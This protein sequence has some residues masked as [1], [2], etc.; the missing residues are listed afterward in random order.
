MKPEIPLERQ[1]E[2]RIKTLERQV[3]ALNSA[4]P[5][6]SATIDDPGTLKVRKNGQDLLHVGKLPGTNGGL[7]GLVVYRED[8]TL[9]FIVGAY[10]A[11]EQYAAL[12]DRSANVIVSDDALSG[13]GLARPYIPIPF[14]DGDA[15]HWGGTSSGTFLALYTGFAYRQHPKF[16]G[17]VQVLA[18]AGT[19]GELEL[20]DATNSVQLDVQS[21]AAAESSYKTFSGVDITSTSA[22]YGLMSLQWRV[23]VTGGAGSIHVNPVF[24]TGI[25]S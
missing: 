17:I 12:Q 18:D 14:G 4:R 9:A 10:A 6:R 22:L 23:R 19:S 2:E 15:S 1:F 20:W 24:C 8:G 7:A 5:L 25:Q 21:I 11:G 16:T 3:D 13:E